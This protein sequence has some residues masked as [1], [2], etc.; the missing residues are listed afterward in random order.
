MSKPMKGR[1]YVQVEETHTC[2]YCHCSSD[3]YTGIKLKQAFYLILGLS[4]ASIC[5]VGWASNGSILRVAAF[6]IVIHRSFPFLFPLKLPGIPPFDVTILSCSIKLRPP[7]QKLFCEG[8]PPKYAFLASHSRILLRFLD[9]RSRIL[10]FQNLSYTLG[11][12]HGAHPHKSSRL[13]INLREGILRFTASC[14]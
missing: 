14:M 9:S 5:G 1:A 7:E 3:Q 4:V 8:T 13:H 6:P 2:R 11:R 10:S 12:A